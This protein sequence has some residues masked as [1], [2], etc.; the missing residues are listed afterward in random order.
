MWPQVRYTNSESQIPHLGHGAVPLTISRE[1]RVREGCAEYG[2]PLHC[3][4]HT[5]RTTDSHYGNGLAE[6]TSPSR[7]GQFGPEKE[8]YTHLARSKASWMT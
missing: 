7:Q 1:D 8:G 3:P 6:V 4:W 5:A 2:E